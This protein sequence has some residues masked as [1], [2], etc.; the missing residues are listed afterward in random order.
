MQL[1][2]LLPPNLGDLRIGIGQVAEG[3]RA[4]RTGLRAGR[5]HLAVLHQP[6]L[7][8][9]G[10][11]RSSEALD[12]EGAFLHDTLGAYRQVRIELHRQRL[13]PGNLLFRIVVPIEVADLVRAVRRA[14]A[15]ADAAVV[16]LRIEA[17]R[18]VI[19]GAHR[20]HRL[21]RSRLALL[22]HHGHELRA[23]AGVSASSSFQYRSMRIQCMVWPCS[24]RSLPTVGTLF[25]A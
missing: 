8:A 4:A 1:H 25:S 16:N 18:R 10:A 19:G 7:G 20:A 21:A 24:N 5:Q 13:R 2:L 17:V 23:V 6:S 3:N 12:A 15:R 14:I 9:R 11:L 22:A